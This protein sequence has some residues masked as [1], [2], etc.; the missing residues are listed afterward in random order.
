MK[1]YVK[2]FFFLAI[3]LAM[4]GSLMA[5]SEPVPGGYVGKV[6]TP[7]GFTG[8]LLAPGNHTCYGRDAMYL[9][10]VSDTKRDVTIHQL[11][12]DKINFSATIG[13]LFSVNRP[14]RKAVNDAF[15]NITPAPGGTT[16][17]AQQLW[18]MYI[19]PVADEE[20][21]GVYAQY[22]SKEIVSKRPA[23]VQEVATA[24]KNAFPS[25]LIKIKL[26][27]VN[28]DDFPDEITKAWE[29]RAAELVK[30]QT[31]RAKQERLIVA[32]QNQ[33]SLENLDYQIQLVRAANIADSN[34][35]IGN[36]ITPGYLAWWQ[37]KVLSQAASGP[38]NWG[39]IPYTD[40]VNGKSGTNIADRLSGGGMIDAELLQRIQDARS[41][42]KQLNDAQKKAAAQDEKSPPNSDKQPAAPKK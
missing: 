24:V 30:V 33:L 13:V 18:N 36:S 32:K 27:T 26:V 6:R 11:T 42:A 15:D 20:A 2:R 40:F 5:C 21:R 22:D 10:E 16:I 28:N 7:D 12:T 3:L 29:N 35:I 38:N 1:I 25:G 17:S 34:K 8:D 37:L 31:E 23:I 14:D 9:L 19:Q 41:K 39:F 4:V